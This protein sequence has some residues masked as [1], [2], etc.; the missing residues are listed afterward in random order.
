MIDLAGS[1]KAGTSLNTYESKKIN[2]SLLVLGNCIH[3]LARN[4][5]RGVHNH[6]PFRDS[7]LTRLLKDSLGTSPF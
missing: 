2:Q 7:K 5:E 6:I 4:S 1:E 3:E